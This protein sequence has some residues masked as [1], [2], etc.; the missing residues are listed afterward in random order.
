MTKNFPKAN[1]QKSKTDPNRKLL[2]L[3]VP[4]S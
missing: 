4:E 1:T 2:F 3:L